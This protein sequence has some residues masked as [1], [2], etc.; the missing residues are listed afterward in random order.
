MISFFANLEKGI[1]QNRNKQITM[2]LIFFVQFFVV[3]LFFLYYLNDEFHYFVLL[4]FFFCFYFL[5]IYFQL[6]LEFCILFSPCTL[7]DCKNKIEKWFTFDCCSNW[8]CVK[9]REV[10]SNHRFSQK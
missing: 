7:L 6:C 4:Y 5:F 2:I 8:K 10:R 3:V 9:V 1:M